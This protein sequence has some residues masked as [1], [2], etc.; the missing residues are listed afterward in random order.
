MSDRGWFLNCICLEPGF[1]HY[2]PCRNEIG[3]EDN[4]VESHDTGCLERRVI[5]PARIPER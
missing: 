5:R 2:E 4:G 1:D 3:D